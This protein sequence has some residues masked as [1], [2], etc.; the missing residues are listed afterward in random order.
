M[1]GYSRFFS[2]NKALVLLAFCFS[3][4]A[5]SQLYNFKKYN[6]KNG[7][8]NS[9]INSIIQSQNG[10]IWFATQGGGLSRFDGKDFKNYT[11]LDGLISNDLSWLVED[12]QNNIWIATTE[13]LSVFDGR[14]FK[15][16]SEKDGISSSTI[17]KMICDSRGDIWIPT[18][19]NGL[20][21]Y[22][23]GK[24]A[25]IDTSNGF[26]T[27]F[28]LCVYQE[29]DDYWV[30]TYKDGLYILDKDGKVKKHFK[31]LDGNNSTS[32]FSI[33]AHEDGTIYF[34]TNNSGI[35]HYK[36]G[37]IKK[38]SIAGIDQD[39]IGA[40]ITDSKKNLWIGAEHGLVKINEEGVKIYREFDGLSSEVI[41]ALCEDYEGNIWIGTSGGGVNLLKR[42]SIVTYTSRDGL[43][44][45]KIS[46]VFRTSDGSLFVSALHGGLN[47]YNKATGKF[48]LIKLDKA[49]ENASIS[50]YC[51]IRPNLLLLG[52]EEN[53]LFL[54][55]NNSGNL[56]LKTK[57]AH[58]KRGDDEND[59][60][61]ILRII[62]DRD[63]RVWVGCFGQ[64][65][66]L[67]DEDGKI[68]EHY[69][70]GKAGL[71]TNDVSTMGLDGSGDLLV[72]GFKQGLQI[73]R[74]GKFVAFDGKAPEALNNSW[75]MDKDNNGTMYFGT[76]DGGLVIYDKGKFINYNASHG[77]CS[78]FIQSIEIGKDVVWLGTDKGVNRL[79]LTPAFEIQELRY[80]GTE[81]GFVSAEI[82]LNSMFMES[83]GDVWFGSSD[84][85][86]RYTEKY[87]YPNVVPPKLVL[88]DIKMFYE[89]VNWSD[90]S[91]KVNT[92]TNI[93][94]ELSLPFNKNHLTFNFRALTVD[95]ATYKF[96]MEGHDDDWS[97]FS[98]SN[99]AVY[100]N[101][102]PGTY[103]FKVVAKNSFGVESKEV[104][105]FS[106]TITPPFWKTWWFYTISAVLVLAGLI[107]FFRWRTANLEKEKRILEQKVNERTAELKTANEHLSVALHDIKDSI[108]YAERIQRAMMPV[109][110]KIHQY[111]PQSFI[112]FRPRDVVSGD[113]YWFNHKDGVDYIAAVD[114][115]G[116]GVPG[117]FMSMVGSSLLNEIVLTKGINNPTEILMQ[118]NVGV[119]NA[120]KQ[121]E[122]KTRDGMDLAFC[123]IDYK[124]R[125]LAYAGANR[126]LW[127][128]RHA[129]GE[130][131]MEEIKA[132]KCAIGGFTDDTQIYQRHE[133]DLNPGDTV[134]LHSDGYADQFGGPQGK[135][136]MTKRFKDILAGIQKQNMPAQETSLAAEIN[137]WM[138]GEYEQ[139]DD[140][141]VI[142]VR[143]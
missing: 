125:K 103:V 43:S 77:L 128:F 61:T 142:G 22:R 90:F 7:L 91:D 75:C 34:G 83:N 130:S 42:E 114:C 139:V 13:G 55:E 137:N 141:L 129:N 76:Q 1:P 112:L 89:H 28:I 16:F 39:L 38:L 54:F 41:Q 65:V 59:V 45:N 126:S 115:T 44:N 124:N 25:T 94:L 32:V 98:T 49:F 96:I 12:K 37:A 51:E 5:F 119:Q 18:S 105:E 23:D 95:H 60:T 3:F 14:T 107:L 108:N 88:A 73:F 72:A 109:Q 100:T 70:G 47:I 99:Q 131:V 106:F 117:A 127:I 35:Y 17:Y 123:A 132:T 52:T 78:N 86:T 31:D 64:G 40:I 36:N 143:F 79:K 97:P 26:G 56:K 93:P 15:S 10:Y 20:K 21:I 101:I 134:Y 50:A 27:N 116:H 111:L 81:D 66:F 138:G 120:L 74:D 58:Y 29:K 136:L 92:K 104:I 122:N 53:G 19:Q 121:R 67:L 46:S 9:N 135:K 63:K 24:F 71:N 140:I 11:K 118:L 6:T 57:F 30:G 8:A 69:Y 82:N 85:L 133:V 87:D 62:K 4:P 68:L 84:G 80:Y 48:D 2:L 33:R 113:F 110:E 102:P